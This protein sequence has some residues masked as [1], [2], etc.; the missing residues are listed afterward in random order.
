MAAVIVEVPT[1]SALIFTPV[2]PIALTASAVA[3]LEL[4][5][6]KLMLSV[7]SVGETV[8]YKTFSSP[9]NIFCDEVSNSISSISF[10]DINPPKKEHADKQLTSEIKTRT[11]DMYLN[12]FITIS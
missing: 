10:F 5:D 11:R 9:T 3:T 2:F 7:Y 1:E 12:F 6:V 4:E 8:K